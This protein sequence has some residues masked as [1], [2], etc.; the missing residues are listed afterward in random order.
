MTARASC[1]ESVH[2]RAPRAHAPTGDG[3]GPGRPN[4]EKI[5]YAY[6][7]NYVRVWDVDQLNS[8]HLVSGKILIEVIVSD[9]VLIEPKLEAGRPI[10]DQFP[11]VTD[12]EYV[13]NNRF[14][15]YNR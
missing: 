2:E 14:V 15:E 10:N 9:K 4:F 7:M 5:A 11:Y 1:A 12:A 6:G 3:R 8:L 13:E